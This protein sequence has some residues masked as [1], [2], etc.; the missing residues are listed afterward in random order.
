MQPA[1]TVPLDHG[2]SWILHASSRASLV[3]DMGLHNHDPGISLQRLEASAN[4]RRYPGDMAV[5]HTIVLPP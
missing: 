1:Q 4:S 5:D 3:T 2:G